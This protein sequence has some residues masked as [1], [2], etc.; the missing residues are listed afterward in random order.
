[1]LATGSS[2]GL[3]NELLHLVGNGLFLLGL[4]GLCVLVERGGEKA[5]AIKPLKLA[6][7]V[8]GYHVIEHI[9]LT[10]SFAMTGTAI[11]ASTLFGNATGAAGST[12]RIWFHFA[13]NLV[14]TVYAVKAIAAAHER[15]LL[16][17]AAEPAMA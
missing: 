2:V 13:I 8:Q 11:G 7:L 6:V 16:L 12:Y 15:E 9:M 4:I 17:S 1:M 5:A 14:A 10:A 3:G